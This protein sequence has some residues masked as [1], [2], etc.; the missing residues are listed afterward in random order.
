MAE[1]HGQPSLK[2]G[3]KT[4]IGDKFTSLPPDIRLEKILEI[5]NM[6]DDT[7]KDCL[8]EQWGVA[9]NPEGSERGRR[10][11]YD[12]CP[13]CIQF[14]PQAYPLTR[15]RLKQRF[16]PFERRLYLSSHPV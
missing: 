10:R 13:H 4:G 1:P 7:L 2:T 8:L 14:P 11:P 12:Q 16:Q 5:Y 6:V 3:L 15:H 9:E